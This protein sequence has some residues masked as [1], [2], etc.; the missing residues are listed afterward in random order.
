MNVLDDTM[1]SCGLWDE[2][3]GIAKRLYGEAQR[4]VRPGTF[5]SW[6]EL[7]ERTRKPWR[8]KA[9]AEMQAAAGVAA[10]DC[11]RPLVP[12]GHTCWKCGGIVAA[13]ANGSHEPEPKGG[14]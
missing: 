7:N 11:T 2:R 6:D 10:C 12:G 5:W 4:K 9:Y 3:E 14:A 13:G 1:N 8:E